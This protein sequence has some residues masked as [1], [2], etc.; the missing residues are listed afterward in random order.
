MDL[1]SFVF[2][3]RALVLIDHMACLFAKSPPYGTI[4]EVVEDSVD[5]HVLLELVEPNNLSPILVTVLVI[6]TLS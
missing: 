3:G 5:G 6:A 4:K 1:C 2:C